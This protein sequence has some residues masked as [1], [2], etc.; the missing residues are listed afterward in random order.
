MAFARRV[1][2]SA[3]C[4]I[5]WSS[6]SVICSSSFKP[7][8]ARVVRRELRDRTARR[9]ARGETR[10][11]AYPLYA[12]ACAWIFRCCPGRE[13]ARRPQVGVNPWNTQP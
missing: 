4:A 1:A 10:C 5:D 7:R 11:A 9:L 6:A 3:R 12:V 8:P 2:V 13:A